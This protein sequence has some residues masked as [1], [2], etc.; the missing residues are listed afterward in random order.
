[1]VESNKKEPKSEGVAYRKWQSEVAEK[2]K[3]MSDDEKKPYNQAATVELEKYKQELS[4][5]ELK[6]IRLGNVDLV[7]EASL[8]ENENVSSKR[9]PRR[10][11]HA[12]SDSD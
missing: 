12:S 1:M 6:M 10:R 11:S 4:K 8:I 5:W 3:K 2:W 9:R 7:R